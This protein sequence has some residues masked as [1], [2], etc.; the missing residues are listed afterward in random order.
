MGDSA[1]ASVNTAV[2]LFERLALY[3]MGI[4]KSTTRRYRI[5]FFRD[6]YKARRENESWKTLVITVDT[7]FGPPLTIIDVEWQ[8]AKLKTFVSTR[9]N[10]LRGEIQYAT[11]SYL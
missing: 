2:A 5:T 4:W 8:D 1:F 10:T 6:W 9:G 11:N 7:D 3:F